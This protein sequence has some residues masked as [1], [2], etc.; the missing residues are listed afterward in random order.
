MNNT[1]FDTV[2]REPESTIDEV[3]AIVKFKIANNIPMAT[4]KEEFVEDVIEDAIDLFGYD[5]VFGK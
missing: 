3:I 2:Y 5:F 4:A 1:M